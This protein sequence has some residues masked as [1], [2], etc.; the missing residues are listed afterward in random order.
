M[1]QKEIRPG[2]YYYAKM[3]DKN[4]IVQVDAVRRVTVG[5]QRPRRIIVYDVSE[6]ITREQAI[7]YS[8]ERFISAAVHRPCTVDARLTG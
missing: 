2:G 8:A 6:P 1:H 7:F 5:E 3:R 4:I